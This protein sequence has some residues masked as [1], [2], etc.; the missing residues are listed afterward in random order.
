MSERTI[1]IDAENAILGR[2]ASYV[3]KNALNGYGVVVVNAEKA[4]FSGTKEAVL[5]EVKNKLRTHTLGSPNKGP[6]HYRRPDN[7]VRR[8]VRGMLPWRK[9]KG[10][11]AFKRVKIYIGEPTEFEKKNFV[12]VPNADASRLQVGC[13]KITVKNIVKEIGGVKG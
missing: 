5:A 3:A 12:K 13:P 7:Y 4:I 9:T 11:E 1:F 8:V 10:R 2:L 6:V